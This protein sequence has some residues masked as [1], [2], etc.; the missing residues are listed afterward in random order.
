MEAT[1][2]FEMWYKMKEKLEQ[3]INFYKS[4]AVK[5]SNVEHVDARLAECKAHLQYMIDM[6]CEDDERISAIKDVYKSS[7]IVMSE[8]L[9]NEYYGKLTT[10]EIKYLLNWSGDYDDIEDIDSYAFDIA[11]PTIMVVDD[12]KFKTQRIFD[13]LKSIMPPKYRIHRTAEYVSAA[14]YIH[15]NMRDGKASEYILLLDWNFPLR[16][17]RCPE[18]SM[19][20]QLLSEI[21]RLGINLKTI[22]VSSDKIDEDKMNFPF[23]MGNIVDDSSIYQ[24][25]QYEDLINKIMEARKNEQNNSSNSSER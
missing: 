19:G 20:H 10:D 7:D 11:V 12:D 21:E 25:K 6:E 1:E 23:V 3:D 5:A 9:R 15:D 24:K 17:D 14:R 4:D 18:A 22:I 2:V 16:A 13:Y 8:L